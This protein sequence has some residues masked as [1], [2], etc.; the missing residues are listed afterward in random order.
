MPVSVVPSFWFIGFSGHRRLADPDKALAALDAELRKLHGQAAAHLVGLSSL[1]IGGDQLF[2]RACRAV[3]IPYEVRLPFP[4]EEF[5]KDFDPPDWQAALDLRKTALASREGE[6]KG[7]R[8]EAYLDC[9]LEIV[10]ECDL[11]VVVWN[12]LKAAGVGGTGEIV[13]YARRLQRPLIWIHSETFEVKTE[14]LP[15]NPFEDKTTD[16]MRKC[17]DV[18]AVG[19]ETLKVPPR[20]AVE[21]LMDKADAYATRWAPQVRRLAAVMVF[22]NLA[23]TILGGAGSI[24]TLW[25]SDRT[26]Q[27]ETFLNVSRFILFVIVF[28]VA[29]SNAARIKHGHWLTCRFTAEVCRSILAT[30]ELPVKTT[31]ALDGGPVEFS[32]L[33]RS[34][35]FL[36]S[37]GDRISTPGQADAVKQYLDD[38]IG[39]LETQRGQIWYYHK[40][41]VGLEP[42]HK[43][44]H[45]AFLTSMIVSAILMAILIVSPFVKHRISHGAIYSGVAT[46]LLSITP[47]LATSALSLIYVFEIQRRL[48]HFK[49]MIG[50]LTRYKAQIAAAAGTP[51]ALEAHV[52]RCERALLGEVQDW[53]YYGLYGK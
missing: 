36:R 5:S 7:A 37:L 48:V 42:W 24:V 12:G 6:M 27:A 41:S 38:R 31:L 28:G 52:T 33:L 2:L 45:F 17:L 39:A 40:K 22:L 4:A 20:A 18:D 49:R 46:Q 16:S 9:G 29:A 15:A 51:S 53:Y 47:L 34:L 11:L 25:H 3:G 23:V 10:D 32:H 30:W 21:L 26:I 8:P 14:N 1:A 43:R 19:E 13:D 50:L 44:L 35:G